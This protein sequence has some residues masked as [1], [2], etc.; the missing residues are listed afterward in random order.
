VSEKK[1]KK[2]GVGVSTVYG[3]DRKKYTTRSTNWGT[4]VS[5][6]NRA[7]TEC[8][9][10]IE[11]PCRRSEPSLRGSQGSGVRRRGTIIHRCGKRWGV[12]KN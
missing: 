9:L 5:E 12:L 1:N 11:K 10:G 6:E 7:W 3:V 4:R 2:S 8:A